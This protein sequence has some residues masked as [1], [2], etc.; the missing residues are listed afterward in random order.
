MNNENKISE[1][2]N[3]FVINHTKE[4]AETSRKIIEK[5]N[6]RLYISKRRQENAKLDSA[7][8]P[9]T[10]ISELFPWLDYKDLLHPPV[11]L[12]DVDP[13]H[14]HTEVSPE[15]PTLTPTQSPSSNVTGSPSKLS[16]N[17]PLKFN[18]AVSGF[19]TPKK[20]ESKERNIELQNKVSRNIF[21]ESDLFYSD[22]DSSIDSAVSGI[23]LR[24][25][26]EVKICRIWFNANKMFKVRELS[27][28]TTQY[29]DDVQIASNNVYSNSYRP[30]VT[31]PPQPSRSP[32]PHDF[33]DGLNLLEQANILKDITSETSNIP[34]NILTD[35]VHM[36]D[37]ESGNSSDSADILSYVTK[38]MERTGNFGEEEIYNKIM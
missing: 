9:P 30:P 34:W 38:N 31:K 32:E 24:A 10:R 5:F 22:E 17:S 7:I 13:P 20:D 4:D 21:S 8:L 6:K 16:S 25:Q 12:T 19:R 3:D 35:D 2:Q 33:L 37:A 14:L 1:Q 18:K 36:L 27:T 26:E 23:L 29:Y 15:P 28:Q 11:T